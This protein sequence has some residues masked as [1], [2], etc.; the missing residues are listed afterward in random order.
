MENSLQNL[1]RL[2]HFM[3][4]NVIIGSFYTNSGRLVEAYAVISSLAR[5]A[6]ACGLDGMTNLNQRPESGPNGYEFPLLLPPT[7]DVEAKDR[8]LLSHAIYLADRSLSMLS[9][10]PSVYKTVRK[11][12]LEHSLP[13][14][15]QLDEAGSLKV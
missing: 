14:Q 9:G 12:S 10:L 11:R 6:L 15:I 1:D 13:G 3:W 2:T 4:A 5:F 8:K 7:S